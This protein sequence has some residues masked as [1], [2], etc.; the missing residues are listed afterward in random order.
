MSYIKQKAETFNNM[1]AHDF[2]IF[3]KKLPKIF[4]KMHILY[5]KKNTNYLK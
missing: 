4:I 2:Y 5:I 3:Y 1:I